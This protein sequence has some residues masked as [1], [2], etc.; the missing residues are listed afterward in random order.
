MYRLTFFW[1]Y[2]LYSNSDTQKKILMEKHEEHG[3]QELKKD[4]LC[5]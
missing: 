1:C 3:M 2:V 5:L 4:Y